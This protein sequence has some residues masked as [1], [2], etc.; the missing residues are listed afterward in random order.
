MAGLPPDRFW[1]L[2]PRLY[3]TE[4]KAAAR[5]RGWERT[6]T[7]EGAMLQRMEKPPGLEEYTGV[8]PPPAPA[9]TL[10]AHLR[11]GARGLRSI[12]LKQYMASKGGG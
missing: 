1:E 5:K 3:S 10:D 4:M 8:K 6:L 2:T 7:W 9:G 11:A 12:T